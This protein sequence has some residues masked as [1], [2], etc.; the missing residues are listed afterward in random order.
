M[1]RIQ[2]YSVGFR[3]RARYAVTNRLHLCGNLVV[4]DRKSFV[5]VT[6]RFISAFRRNRCL[7]DFLLDTVKLDFNPIKVICGIGIRSNAV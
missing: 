7:L 2:S 3:F 4:L 6:K 1:I 5:A